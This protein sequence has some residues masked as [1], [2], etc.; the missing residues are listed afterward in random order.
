MGLAPHIPNIN[1][2]LTF[3]SRSNDIGV[4]NQ[5]CF[6]HICCHKSLDDLVLD[7]FTFLHL[8]LVHVV[9]CHNRNEPSCQPINVTSFEAFY[10]KG[11]LNASMPHGKILC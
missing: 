6:V 1:I 7:E 2:V 5:P 9:T 3:Q 4:C 8:C 11:E 10:I